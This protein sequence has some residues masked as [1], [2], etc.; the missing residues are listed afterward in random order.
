MCQIS[1]ELMSDDIYHLAEN[2][3]LDT[4]DS[5]PYHERSGDGTYVIYGDTVAIK[6]SLGITTGQPLDEE[7]WRTLFA[8]F[9]PETGDALCQ[10]AGEK[11][12]PGV[13]DICF[14]PEK[15]ISALAALTRDITLLGHYYSVADII[16]DEVG[17]ASEIAMQYL[18]DNRAFVSRRGSGNKPGKRRI[19]P[20]AAIVTANVAHDVS[21]D[22][23]PQD[24]RHRPSMMF[25]LRGDGTFGAIESKHLM[26]F[27]RPAAK[28]MEVALIAGL[29][30]RL[31]LVMA[32]SPENQTFAI[33]AVPEALKTCWSKRSE[34]IK[35]DMADR[36]LEKGVDSSRVN[37]SVLG[38]RRSKEDLP[39][40]ALLI[41]RHQ[42]EAAA[43]LNTLNLTPEQV[44][45]QARQPLP[46]FNHQINDRAGMIVA[47]A[48][49]KLTMT[50]AVFT[51]INLVNQ[52]LALGRGL[53][54]TR[55]VFKALEAA[56]TPH[57]IT[58]M[59][60]IERLAVDL[61]S[62]GQNHA[63]ITTWTTP[64]MMS[65]EKRMLQ[66]A[67]RNDERDFVSSEATETTISNLQER[68]NV[69]GKSLLGE[70]ES[71][72]RHAFG[73]NG[74]V[75]VRGAVGTAKST[76]T[77][78]IYEAA[79]LMGANISVYAPSNRSNQVV[80]NGSGV[81]KTASL[82][83]LVSGLRSGM[84]ALTEKDWIVL[85]EGRFSNTRDLETLLSAA[86][87]A[88]AKV[89]LIGDDRSLECVGT[90]SPVIAI[91]R[92]IGLGSIADVRHQQ[93]EWQRQASE[94]MAKGDKAMI[95]AMEAYDSH[96]RI[97][98]AADRKDAIARLARAWGDNVKEHGTETSRL[99]IC[100]TQED[101]TLT[102]KALRHVWR[103]TG[104]LGAEDFTVKSMNKKGSRVNLDLADGDKILFGENILRFKIHNGDSGHINKV[105]VGGDNKTYVQFCLD[106]RT[107]TLITCKWHELVDYRGKNDRRP[108]LIQHAYTRTNHTGQ[109]STI[110]Y[111]YIFGGN[112]LDQRQCNVGMTSHR[113]DCHLFIDCQRVAETI[114]NR[115][116]NLALIKEQVWKEASTVISHSNISD[117]IRADKLRDW[118]NEPTIE[119]TLEYAGIPE[120]LMEEAQEARLDNRRMAEVLAANAHAIAELQAR[121]APAAMP[122]LVPIAEAVPV[123][124]DTHVVEHDDIMALTT[125]EGTQSEIEI[126]Y[127]ELNYPTPS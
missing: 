61:I 74:V 50:E 83:K 96:N 119:P 87:R 16:R 70:Q 79:D 125:G 15:T 89:Y 33:C 97:H 2:E 64:I 68:L 124:D 36:G 110:E 84:V 31:S 52:V 94:E 12:R 56:K 76:V 26:K 113:Q 92:L 112:S 105:W 91:I 23:D 9:S 10:N 57:A 122:D 95:A 73:R 117:T 38:T 51:E 11:N 1:M 55:D 25:C 24:H 46:R 20:A 19:E 8:G 62:L 40:A 98:W 71:A 18:W 121:I 109:S 6:F 5:I 13:I 85:D 80:I 4:P 120:K 88:G 107:E 82:Q 103:E 48:V 29:Q 45:A 53:V 102:N 100:S 43:I 54:D 35:K 65:A 72:L 77:S 49:G 126:A 47:A 75:Y 32:L 63:G 101:V 99:V 104:H 115:N 93:V 21:R 60:D 42:A 67:D 22:G 81:K 37:Q 78:A 123:I 34:K 30:R 44:L 28:I 90:G 114:G 66:A 59:D 3:R 69:G 17:K 106:R 58:M 108:P 7:S 27:Q 118:Y 41:A 39:P 14:S 116:G 127:E 86:K 111:T